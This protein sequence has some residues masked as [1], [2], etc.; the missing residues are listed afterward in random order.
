MMEEGDKTECYQLSKNNYCLKTCTDCGDAMDDPRTDD[1][2]KSTTNP[3]DVND[4]TPRPGFYPED[5][6]PPPESNLVSC[7]RAAFLQS[8]GEP[9]VCNRLTEKNYCLTACQAPCNVITAKTAC[10]RPCENTEPLAKGWISCDEITEENRAWACPLMKSKN[11]CLKKC[12][13][14]DPSAT[15]E[16][17]FDVTYYINTYDDINRAF[18]N[19]PARA[20]LHWIEYGKDEGRMGCEGCGP[21]I[22]QV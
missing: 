5:E 14:C 21:G 2:K 9:Y 20:R 10:S 4:P 7:A 17:P 3:S 22:G 1:N 6:E 12:G 15:Q 16:Q 8:E 18:Y 13:S 11:Y 19:D